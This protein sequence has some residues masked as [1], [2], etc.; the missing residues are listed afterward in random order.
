VEGSVGGDV[1]KGMKELV[2]TLSM[3]VDEVGKAGKGEW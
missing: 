1:S 3:A 2:T